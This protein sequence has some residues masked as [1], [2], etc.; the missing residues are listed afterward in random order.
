MVGFLVGVEIGAE[1][2]VGVLMLVV[3]SNAVD[4]VDVFVVVVGEIFV[5]V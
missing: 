1:V 5:C 2:W 4:V 3:I